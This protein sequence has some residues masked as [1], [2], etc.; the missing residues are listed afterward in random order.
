MGLRISEVISIR[1]GCVKTT[2]DGYDYMEV[3]LGKTEKGEPINHKVFINEIVKDV[4]EELT[5][6]TEPLR[7]ESGLKE[8]FLCRSR[9]K[10]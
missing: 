2:S 10:N 1:K 3:T 9:G 8:L 6:K 5:N 7:K 4:V